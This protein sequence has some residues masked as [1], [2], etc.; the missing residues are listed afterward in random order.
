MALLITNGFDIQSGV[1]Q[2]PSSNATAIYY[3]DKDLILT[4][5]IT[6]DT[7]TYGECYGS[8]NDFRYLYLYLATS[9]NADLSGG[10]ASHLATWTAYTGRFTYQTTLTI[11]ANTYFNLYFAFYRGWRTSHLELRWWPGIGYWWE[12]VYDDHRELQYHINVANF[13]NLTIEAH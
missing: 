3:T 13:E 2:Q 10:T 12:T 9:K 1:Y 5:S 4:I 7:S 8:G 11:P 6:P